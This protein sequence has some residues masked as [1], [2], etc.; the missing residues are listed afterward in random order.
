MFK[1]WAII[2]LLLSFTFITILFSSP[3]R[4][5]S[6]VLDYLHNVFETDKED[7]VNIVALFRLARG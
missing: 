6:E 2:Y 1:K 4:I 3:D 7:L 5:V